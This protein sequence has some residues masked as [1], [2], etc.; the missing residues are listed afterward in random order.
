MQSTMKNSLLIQVN[1]L[2]KQLSLVQEETN[3]GVSIT[4]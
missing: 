4:N 3:N 1:S 2:V